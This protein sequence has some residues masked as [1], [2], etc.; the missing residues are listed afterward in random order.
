[1]PKISESSIFHVFWNLW[2]SLNPVIK[3]QWKTN[4]SFTNGR[5]EK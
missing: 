5:N 1:M 4:E 2:N 3:K